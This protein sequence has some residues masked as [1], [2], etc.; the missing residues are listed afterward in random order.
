MN[1]NPGKYIKWLP[2]IGFI[3]VI[4]FYSCKTHYQIASEQYTTISSPSSLERGRNLAMNVC[5]GCHFNRQLNKFVGHKMNDLPKFLGKIYSANLTNSKR[6]GVLQHYTD[7]Q[8]AYL[9]KTG[10]KHD[11]RFIPYMIR[12][13]MA[14]EDVNDI[15]VYLRSGD[16][17]LQA[18]DTI[19][20]R[21]HLTPIGKLANSTQKPQKYKTGIKRP[22]A[23]NP[24][25]NGRYL[26]DILG[27]FHCHSKGVLSLNYA[28][29]EDSKGYMQGGMKFKN[30]Q[31]IRV[32]ASNLT[33]DR[34]TGIGKYNKEDFRMA[35]ADGKAVDGRQLSF[36][37]PKFKHLMEKQI[38]EIYSYLKTLPAREHHIK[39]HPD[40]K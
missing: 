19:V 7:A 39:G 36:P 17:P 9:I 3:I 27:C 40:Y 20:G 14:D 31:G 8:L 12:P 22:A 13:T 25:A 34:R 37:M 11:G 18:G 28:N 32:R 33:P 30:M 15:I 26:I 10:I 24:V 35:V 5:G 4:T 16:E 21:T 38:D 6:Y 1:K 29:P 23:D 2:V